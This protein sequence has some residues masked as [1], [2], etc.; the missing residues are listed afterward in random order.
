MGMNDIK[1]LYLSIKGAKEIKHLSEQQKSFLKEL[2][3]QAMVMRDFCK[4]LSR[5]EIKILIETCTTETQLENA[6]RSKKI[7]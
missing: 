5:S 3:Y 4:P 1:K 7:A 6:L 2:Q